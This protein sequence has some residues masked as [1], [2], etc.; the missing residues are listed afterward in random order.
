MNGTQKFCK[1]ALQV[2]SCPPALEG[3]QAKAVQNAPEPV[4]AEGFEA[5]PERIV[6]DGIR[7][8]RKAEDTPKRATVAKLVIQGEETGPAEPEHAQHPQQQGGQGDAS[9]GS[10]PTVRDSP[11][12]IE[13]LKLAA[14]PS[15]EGFG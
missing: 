8:A 2:P 7:I 13:E 4:E 15:Q 3:P 9:A 10:V 1:T 5:V 12:G 14:N 11:K 6:R